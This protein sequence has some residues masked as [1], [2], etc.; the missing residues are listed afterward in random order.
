MSDEI[1]QVGNPE[2]HAEEVAR[3]ERFQFGQNWARFLSALTSEQIDEAMKS[4]QAM[5]GIESLEGRSFLDAGSGSGLFSLSARKL[6]AKVHSFDYDPQSVACTKELKK[7]YFPSDPLWT[8]S[9]GSVLDRDFLKCLGRFNIVYSWGVLH[10]TGAMWDALANVSDLVADQG[11]LFIAIYNYQ[12]RKSARWLKVKKTYCSGAFGRWLIVSIFVPYFFLSGFGIDLLR[13]KNPTL[14]YTEYKKQL[15][16][17][18]RVRDWFDW[19]GGYP[20]EVA[21]PEEIFD[22]YFKRGYHLA[23]LKTVAGRHGCN[24]FVFERQSL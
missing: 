7:R 22:F 20:F 13:G 4:L 23:K 1:T 5:L 24:E 18:S 12:E 16:G 21:S 10:H 9:Q 2:S 14:R 11:K 15:R 8:I 6:G 19:L 3:G 17:M